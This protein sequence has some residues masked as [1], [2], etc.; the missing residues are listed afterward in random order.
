MS[1]SP[2]LRSS[3]YLGAVSVAHLA[4]LVTPNFC[5]ADVDERRSLPVL[6][7]RVKGWQQ[8]HVGRDE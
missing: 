4:E 1:F 6:P 7:L 3:E 5:V 8:Q 2:E